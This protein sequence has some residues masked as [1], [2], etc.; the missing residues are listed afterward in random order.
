[1]PNDSTPPDLAA[2]V[3][4]SLAE[5]YILAIDARTGLRL[6]RDYRLRHR[7]VIKIMTQKRAKKS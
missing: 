5:N 4:T 1:M 6:P 3:H 7:D 2:T